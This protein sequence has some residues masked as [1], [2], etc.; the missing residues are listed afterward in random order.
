MASDEGDLWQAL[1]H[2]GERFATDAEY[3]HGYRRE[4]RNDL[5]RYVTFMLGDE[6]YGLP[7]EQV[8]EIATH[9]DTTPVPRTANFV[10]GIGNVRGLV[11]PVLD[12]NLRLRLERKVDRSNARILIVRHEDDSYG[13]VV[14]RVLEVISLPPEDMEETPGGI[15]STRADFIAAIGRRKDELIIVLDIDTVLDEREFIL[16][17]YRRERHQGVV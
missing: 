11:M 2:T 1:L 12:L 15:G 3:E 10:L 8:V 5:R 4:I 14:D 7:I 6:T 17:A 9:F 13:L 16:P